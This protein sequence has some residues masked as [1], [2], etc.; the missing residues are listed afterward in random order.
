[1]IRSKLQPG[2]SGNEYASL[3]RSNKKEN[4]P[5]K[6]LSRRTQFWVQK[7][8]SKLASLNQSIVILQPC[9]EKYEKINLNTVQKCDGQT[10]QNQSRTQA[11]SKNQI[12]LLF[13]QQPTYKSGIEE[14]RTSDFPA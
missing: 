13:I 3:A 1:M 8:F 6:S 14:A 10:V 9:C 12:Y 4:Y 7:S 11:Q 2:A 5:Q